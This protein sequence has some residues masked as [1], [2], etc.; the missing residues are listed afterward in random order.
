MRILRQIGIGDNVRIL[1][2]RHFGFLGK[3]DLHRLL[4]LRT[5]AKEQKPHH[6]AGQKQNRGSPSLSS[7]IGLHLALTIQAIILDNRGSLFL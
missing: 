7:I 6:A 4:L 3:V 1:L 2:H 5:R